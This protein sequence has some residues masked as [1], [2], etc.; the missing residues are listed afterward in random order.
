MMLDPGISRDRR[1][2]TA[3]ASSLSRAQAAWLPRRRA[4]ATTPGLLLQHGG[5]D[6]RSPAAPSAGR[7]TAGLDGPAPDAEPGPELE[8]GLEPGVGHDGEAAAEVPAKPQHGFAGRH[9]RTAA[10][11]QTV[12][13]R[14]GGTGSRRRTTTASA[15][16]APAGD[17]GDE[18]GGEA[19]QLPAAFLSGRALSTGY[20]TAELLLLPPHELEERLTELWTETGSTQKVT[21]HCTHARDRLRMLAES[22]WLGPPPPAKGRRRRNAELAAAE[23]AVAA[24][25]QRALA[26]LRA[27]AAGGAA[28]YPL[29]VPECFLSRRHYKTNYMTLELLMGPVTELEAAVTEVWSG[30]DTLLKLMRHKAEAVHRLRALEAMGWFSA[31][32]SGGGSTRRR[33]GTG[34]RATRS[35]QGAG[36]AA[37]GGGSAGG[38]DGA[39]ALQVVPLTPADLEERLNALHRV[40]Q[41]LR[42]VF[43]TEPEN[44]QDTATLVEQEDVQQPSA[45]GQ[46]ATAKQQRAAAGHAAASSAEAEAGAG[47]EGGHTAVV[48]ADGYVLDRQRRAGG[49]FQ[50]IGT[51]Y[52]TPSWV[53][54][55]CGER[56]A[57]EE[58][59]GP[60]AADAR[61]AA[62]TRNVVTAM[63]A[64]A[65]A[66]A[67]APGG[68]DCSGLAA[69]L[70]EKMRTICPTRDSVFFHARKARKLLTDLGEARSWAPEV[71]AARDAAALEARR[72][73]CLAL[74]AAQLPG[75]ELAALEGRELA[76]RLRALWREKFSS[77]RLV[78]L[79]EERLRDMAAAGTHPA[80][81]L[82]EAQAAAVRLLPLQWLPLELL[83]TG[84]LPPA[85]ARAAH[86]SH[87]PAAAGQGKASSRGRGSRESASAGGA[88][89]STAEEEGKE[90]GGQ[91]ALGQESAGEREQLL[92][93]LRGLSGRDLQAVLEAKIRDWQLKTLCLAEGEAEAALLVAFQ[94]GRCSRAQLVDR[95]AVLSAAKWRLMSQPGVL[96]AGSSSSSS[97]GSGKGGHGFDAA[98]SLGA[99]DEGEGGGA[100]GGSV[101]ESMDEEEDEGGLDGEGEAE[102]E[103]GAGAVDGSRLKRSPLVGLEVALRPPQDVV[104]AVR[105]ACAEHPNV[106]WRTHAQR[107]RLQAFRAQAAGL[108][109][110]QQCA[111]LRTALTEAFRKKKV[112]KP[113]PLSRTA[114]LTPQL[115]AL[116]PPQL[117][118]ALREGLLTHNYKRD[119]LRS[120]MRAALLRVRS[121]YG[122]R[123]YKSLGAA[124][125]YDD[126]AAGGDED[127]DVGDGSSVGAS[128]TGTAAALG[129]RVGDEAAFAAARAAVEEAGAQALQEMYRQRRQRLSMDQPENAND[130]WVSPSGVTAG[131]SSSGASGGASTEQGWSAQSGASER[132]GGSAAA[133]DGEMS[134]TEAAAEAAEELRLQQVA[135]GLGA[136]LQALPPQ[137]LAERL[138]LVVSLQPGAVPVTLM[139]PMLQHVL[140]SDLS[141]PRRAAQ[142]ADYLAGTGLDSEG[143]GRLLTALRRRLDRAAAAGLLQRPRVGEGEAVAKDAVVVLQV[144][145]HE[146]VM[147]LL[148]LAACSVL[149][150]CGGAAAAAIGVAAAAEAEAGV[151]AEAGKEQAEVAAPAL[152]AEASGG[153]AGTGAQLGVWEGM[154]GPVLQLA[155]GEREALL[156]AGLVDQ[157]RGRLDEAAVA[158]A[159]ADIAAGMARLPPAHKSSL[160]QN[161]RR[162]LRR[163]F[164]AGMA[165]E[166]GLRQA[167]TLVRLASAQ[168]AFLRSGKSSGEA[169]EAALAAEET[170]AARQVAAAVGVPS[171]AFWE[172][173]AQGLEARE[174]AVGS[175]VEQWRPL[176]PKAREMLRRR[177]YAWLGSAAMD[178]DISQLAAKNAMQVMKGATLELRR[179]WTRVVRAAGRSAR[180]GLAA[181]AGGAQPSGSSL[182]AALDEQ[183]LDSLVGGLD[184]NGAGLDLD[185]EDEGGEADGEADDDSSGEEAEEAAE[186]EAA[187][188][189]AGLGGGGGEGDSD[190]LAEGGAGEAASMAGG[191]RGKRRTTRPYLIAPKL[192][193]LEPEALRD[194]LVHELAGTSYMQRKHLASR[195]REALRTRCTDGTLDGE[196]LRLRLE[197]VATA[198]KVVG[199]ML[200]RASGIRSSIS[201]WG[202]SSSG[203]GGAGSSR[204]EGEGEAEGEGGGE[205]G[206]GG[207]LDTGAQQ[208]DGEA[209]AGV[210][211]QRSRAGRR[212]AVAGMT[213]EQRAAVPIALSLLEP[214]HLVHTPPQQL[215]QELTVAWAALDPHSQENHHHYARQRLRALRQEGAM[216]EEAY[217]ARLSAFLAASRAVRLARAGAAGGRWSGVAEAVQAAAVALVRA[218]PAAG[219]ERGAL[220]ALDEVRTR[221]AVQYADNEGGW[222]AAVA[223]DAAD[224]GMGTGESA[225]ASLEVLQQRAAALRATEQEARGGT[226]AGGE[227]K[228]GVGG[229]GGAGYYKF[230]L[231]SALGVEP[232]PLLRRWAS[233]PYKRYT[234]LATINR[235]LLQ[236][237]GSPELALLSAEQLAVAELELELWH[238]VS[239]VLRKDVASVALSRSVAA[240]AKGRRGEAATTAATDA[241]AGEPRRGFGRLSVQQMRHFRPALV[242]RLVAAGVDLSE[243]TQQAPGA[244]VVESGS[245]NGCRTYGRTTKIIARLQAGGAPQAAHQPEDAALQP[246]GQQVE[247]QEGAQQ[248]EE[249]GTTQQQ[250]EED[251]SG[252]G[253]GRLTAA[254]AQALID[255]GR[256]AE[257]MLDHRS[258]ER[259]KFVL[260]EQPPLTKLLAPPVDCRAA[261]LEHFTAVGGREELSKKAHALQEWRRR[262]EALSQWGIIGPR[263]HAQQ[264][265]ALLA[266][267]R[268]WPYVV[269]GAE[270]DVV[271]GVVRSDDA[272]RKNPR[273]EALLT[274][275]E[276]QEIAEWLA[277][278]WRD[279]PD[280]EQRR[281]D[282]NN[283]RWRL[284]QLVEHGVMDQG[285]AAARW[286]VILTIK[287]WWREYTQQGWSIERIM[288]AGYKMNRTNVFAEAEEV[289][290]ARRQAKLL[291]SDKPKPL[292]LS[293]ARKPKAADGDAA[294]QTVVASS[295]GRGRPRASV[296]ATRGA[297]AAGAAGSGGLQLL[298]STRSMGG[299]RGRKRST[300]GA[301]DSAL[302]DDLVETLEGLGLK[303]AA[304]AAARSLDLQ[305]E[306]GRTA[307]GL[308]D[309]WWASRARLPAPQSPHAAGAPGGVLDVEATAVVVEPNA[310]AR[311]GAAAAVVP[312]ASQAAV[313]VAA[314]ASLRGAADGLVAGPPA[315]PSPPSPPAAAALPQQAPAPAPAVM[316]EQVPPDVLNKVARLMELARRQRSHLFALQG[317]PGLPLAASGGTVLADTGALRANS[318]GLPPSPPSP[319]EVVAAAKATLDAVEA[320]LAAWR[321]QLPAAALASLD[322]LD[323]AAQEAEHRQLLAQAAAAADASSTAAAAAA[324]TAA[325]APAAAVAAPPLPQAGAGGASASA[326]APTAS[327]GGKRAGSRRATEQ[328]AAAPGGPAT[329]E[330]AYTAQGRG[331]DGGPDSIG[332]APAAGGTTA[333]GSHSSSSSSSSS[334]R[335][336]SGTDSRTDANGASA[337]AGGASSSW[338]DAARERMRA[339]AMAGPQPGAGAPAA[340]LQPLAA[341]AAAAPGGTA[342]RGLAPQSAAAGAGRQRQQ[343][344]TVAIS[345]AARGTKA[346]AG[347]KA[348]SSHALSDV[349]E[350]I[351]SSSDESKKEQS[352]APQGST[353]VGGWVKEAPKQ[354][355]EA[356]VGQQ[357]QIAVDVAQLKSKFFPG[358]ASVPK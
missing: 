126:D 251:G 231:T 184:L 16:E 42:A 186:A 151:A 272:A 179:E 187:E 312:S 156:V 160:I 41:P 277:Q 104:A 261:V 176:G 267:S 350:D 204:D 129:V 6:Q 121:L 81:Q 66:A 354:Q 5:R 357:Q 212:A 145:S 325:A 91:A 295:R 291:Q 167:E 12:A 305:E 61:R 255:A 274:L 290:N 225:M 22:G 266:V 47:A 241:A 95:L 153:T 259:L 321:A 102:E 216:A 346:A 253:V 177:I 64:A 90:K 57:K 18:A 69:A 344:A 313:E 34:G 144:R 287:C 84:S 122:F 108:L 157:C 88:P 46:Q 93:L 38:A 24:A 51:A 107:V 82:L 50:A 237:L 105:A 29:P 137:E 347:S 152:G 171:P 140:R 114:W 292:K 200:M 73:G 119:E 242:G 299:R 155:P 221:L 215:Q 306:G 218:V 28:P 149:D 98:A 268:A 205:G 333:A 182:G 101:D 19:R 300:A 65:A 330:E 30:L 230:V 85:A 79:V 211:T 332:A 198:S 199:A 1:D 224:A 217:N 317:L 337:A 307:A 243:P 270:F 7:R 192:A 106:H 276:P 115:L 334:S 345:A 127:V 260:Q 183:Y 311:H 195:V 308:E 128:F 13:V 316:L 32:S 340:S 338:L 281:R 293:Q 227:G 180:Q 100:A 304:E 170:V 15:S 161:T 209:G 178:G 68:P 109:T 120:Q 169:A 327:A 131:A 135:A 284:K 309:R 282:N 60:E 335:S 25:Q 94:E 233:L 303:D 222:A 56:L 162:N 78:L 264:L 37:A 314:A 343:R 8:P 133:A 315:T 188:E 245:S 234:N 223:A 329:P 278:R 159:V 147:R 146:L 124:E 196:G 97:S 54:A 246:Q 103:E 298:R 39:Q 77:T 208:Q 269:R 142:L 175:L 21:A 352:R 9:N 123:H 112:K 172:E 75:P 342:G 289:K 27:L 173:A 296:P 45:A 48:R 328:A 4:A 226:P 189:G 23:E 322:R 285:T 83:M 87:A 248:E 252:D 326:P 271:A 235:R 262:L 331:A 118:S 40:C 166:A 247:L 240:R 136:G 213:P 111:E 283:L 210:R 72:I 148:L 132:A 202:P 297:A 294:A 70:V 26:A 286:Q 99:E 318:N 2:C 36:G 117:V 20:L 163:A 165:S 351:A 220:A 238:E 273:Y 62:A 339:V 263:L 174:A 134:D 279:M 52:L 203:G 33:R 150:A 113:A 191:Q 194:A 353:S 71:R 67:A 63:A 356:Q 130:E 116:P 55:A 197:A 355:L 74:E 256:K 302:D 229:D 232:E 219:G 193:S 258:Y 17:G 349:G 301:T 3:S 31:G 80:P 185:G 254:E 341:A 138:G 11:R 44:E 168:A 181:A 59:D 236:Q 164:E 92:Q 141:R 288:Q 143:R 320:R 139:D 158:A 10:A 76:A 280:P 249:E 239:K 35:T 257:A 250:Q 125:S 190:M 58:E 89:S 244:G 319:P 348:P 214:E 110:E 323:R 207:S 14:R 324:A 53:L 96:P 275:S 206:P 43:T 336:S 265:E 49:T 154:A 86:T 358:A 228:G 310:V 201:R